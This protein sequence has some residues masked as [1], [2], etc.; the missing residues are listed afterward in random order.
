MD[1]RLFDYKLPPELIAQ[2]PLPRGSERLMILYRESG[3]IEHRKFRDIDRYLHEGDCL[4]VN[5]TKVIPARLTGK[6]KTGGKVELLLVKR[7]EDQEWECLVRT[8]K[9]PREGTE[10]YLDGGMRARVE[11]RQGDVFRVRFSSPRVLDA[12]RIPLPPYIKRMPEQIDEQTY[13]T[14]YA[15]HA[16]S[17]AAP[18]AGLHFT[19]SF[20][21]GLEEKGVDIVYITLHVGPGTFA[22]VRSKKVEEHRMHSEDFFVSEHAA[23]RINTALSEG[24]RVIAVGTTTTRVIEHLLATESKIVSG[25]GST[26]LFIY[27]GFKFRGIDAVLT[28]F[29]LPRST[30]LMLVCAFGGYKLVMNAYSQAI[31]RRYRFF[32]YGDAML[33]L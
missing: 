22:P 6:K 30:L 25:K 31:E 21:R 20:L 15:R 7:L 1:L 4:V 17:V 5:D 19:S 12:G 26:D 9:T 33:I 3:D 27:P 2:Y 10:I 14:V 23:K 29:H 32:S 28:N 8:S 18:T 16:G 24:R 11:G 13:Q